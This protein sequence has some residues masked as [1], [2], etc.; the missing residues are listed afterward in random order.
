MNNG[1]QRGQNQQFGPSGSMGVSLPPG[2]PVQIATCR[3]GIW[4]CVLANCASSSVFHFL[5]VCRIGWTGPSHAVWQHSTRVS[6]PRSPGSKHCSGT[7]H[8]EQRA[9]LLLIPN[10]ALP[11]D[12][13]IVQLSNSL[14]IVLSIMHSQYPDSHCVAESGAAPPTAGHLKAAPP[15]TD[16]QRISSC[17]TG[18]DG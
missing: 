7:L 4:V 18:D 16:W 12:N 15:A 9:L 14:V 5:L 13:N 8:G 1:G 6:C 2:M 10:E 17:F 3:T 11:G